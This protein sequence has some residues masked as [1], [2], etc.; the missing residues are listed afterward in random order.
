MWN[1]L[2]PTLKELSKGF[3]QTGDDGYVGPYTQCMDWD[4]VK[5]KLGNA[6]QP[7]CTMPS[8]GP[9]A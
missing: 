4:K 7:M 9:Q 3:F 2:P 8:D 1:R 6:I 5:E